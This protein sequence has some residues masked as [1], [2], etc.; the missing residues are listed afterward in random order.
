MPD[1]TRIAGWPG[2]LDWREADRSTGGATHARLNY[3]SEPHSGIP[4]LGAEVLSLL[5]QKLRLEFAEM[6]SMALPFALRVADK[7]SQDRTTLG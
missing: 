4:S 1:T 6:L 3:S 2:D 7:R 5:A